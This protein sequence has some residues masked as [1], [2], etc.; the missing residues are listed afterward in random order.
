M[1]DV[2]YAVHTAACTY[3]LDEEGV[4]R[5]VMSSTGTIPPDGQQC[6]G[7]QFVACLDLR[8]AGGLVGELLIGASILFVRVDEES[9]RHVLMRTGVIE[10]V[11][12]RRPVGP[13]AR[14]APLPSFQDPTE[15]PLEESLD[16]E[17]LVA[18]EGG[19]VT[20]TIPLY[21]PHVQPE[22]AP[23]PHRRRIPA[24]PISDEA[25]SRDRSSTRGRRR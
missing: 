23:A 25:L 6:V 22:P 7:A 20:L 10:N 14:E 24:P 17:D 21:R 8:V 5:W 9:G 11:E 19:A 15:E 13:I 4:C 16:P 2:T 12:F 3:L 1:S 18:Y